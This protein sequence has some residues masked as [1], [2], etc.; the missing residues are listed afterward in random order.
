MYTSKSLAQH[1]SSIPDP[2]P[3]AVLAAHGKSFYFAS[4]FL[5]NH[6]AES[7]AQL[8]KFC[9]FLDDLADGTDINR[10]ER[11]KNIHGYL[12]GEVR[13]IEDEHETKNFLV[14]AKKKSI[15]LAA[16]QE[17][18]EGMISDQIPARFDN[19]K[20]LLR[21][22][23]AVA[24]T[25]G[26]MMCRVLDCSQKD[27]D[28]FAID[29]G[30][31]MQLTNIARDVL[32]D[33]QMSRRYIPS[34]WLNLNEL[35]SEPCSWVDASIDLRIKVSSAIEQLLKLAEQ[36]YESAE[37]GIVLLPLRSRFAI[38]VALRIYRQIGRQLQ[39]KKYCWWQGRQVVSAFK[40]IQ[41]TLFGLSVFIPRKTPTHQQK[42]HEPLLG[43]AGVN[44][45]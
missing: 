43:L 22:C 31:A 39:E 15:P 21:Y 13:L 2:K 6:Y 29:L 41:L 35:Q 34:E 24:G 40:K 37:Q 9:R 12:A 11:L 30:V 32:E 45:L 20:Q 33:A 44:N 17:L 36:Y 23:H 25:V 10:I 4:L 26:L 19:T 1:Q 28:S 18:V 16:A 8:Y 5:G 3:I 14:L 42:L 7:A 27:A 38:N